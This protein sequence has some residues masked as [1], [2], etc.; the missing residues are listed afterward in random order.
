MQYGHADIA[1]V[2]IAAGADPS[3]PSVWLNVCSER[4]HIGC[5][6]VL[7]AAGADVNGP[8]VLDMEERQHFLPGSAEDDDLAISPLADACN[9]PPLKPA[10]QER[11]E[12]RAR[13]GRRARARSPTA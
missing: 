13:R 7:L 3:G 8:E 4:N 11:R 6:E 12:A 5:A 2:L 1:K 9:R 10:E